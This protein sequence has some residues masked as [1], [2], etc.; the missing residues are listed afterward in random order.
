LNKTKS[1]ILLSLSLFSFRMP[2]ETFLIR[3]TA[4]I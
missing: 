2:L 3:A 1:S 4:G